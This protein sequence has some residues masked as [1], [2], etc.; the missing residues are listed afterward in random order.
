MKKW[1]DI[2]DWVAGNDH[3]IKGMILAV[4]S[5]MNE[6]F[7]GEDEPKPEPAPED[8]PDYSCPHC[9]CR[10]DFHCETC[11][12]CITRPFRDLAAANRRI[13]QLTR[14]RDE[15]ENECKVQIRQ[16]EAE[17]DG[18]RAQAIQDTKDAAVKALEDDGWSPG[19][20]LIDTIR[21]LELK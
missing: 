1:K 14:E 3:R 15:W 8:P 9:G 2:P 12:R 17:R 11:E 4:N 21:N 13:A 20:N 5:R 16:A 10:T 19:S 6:L 18:I 7:S